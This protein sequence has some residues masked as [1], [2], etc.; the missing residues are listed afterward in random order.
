MNNRIIATDNTAD[1]PVKWDGSRTFTDWR[2]SND[3]NNYTQH[4]VSNN[5]EYRLFL[6]RN[7][8]RLINQQMNNTYS[9]NQCTTCDIPQDAPLTNVEPNDVGTL[10]QAYG[11]QEETLL[12]IPQPTTPMTTTDVEPMSFETQYEPVG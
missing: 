3:F 6:Q 9:L 12:N 5:N 7:G 4:N 8:E 2:L 11:Q 1:C 10:F